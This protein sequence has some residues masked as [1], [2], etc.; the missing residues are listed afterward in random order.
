MRGSPGNFAASPPPAP[1]RAPPPCHPPSQ[2]EILPPS[3]GSLESAPPGLLLH[4]SCLCCADGNFRN[5]PPSRRRRER[6][7]RNPQ[8]PRALVLGG[9]GAVGL[10][11]PQSAW[12]GW[13]PLKKAA[14]PGSSW[15]GPEQPSPREK[16]CLSPESS[17]RLGFRPLQRSQGFLPQEQVNS[18]FPV[19]TMQLKWIRVY[20]H[21][22]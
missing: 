10:G 16:A 22:V 17:S 2:D 13:I 14:S 8:A 11:F 15:T 18:N 7:L 21:P 3:T 20:H 6:L 19:Q 9:L 12:G 5:M 1:S 4:V